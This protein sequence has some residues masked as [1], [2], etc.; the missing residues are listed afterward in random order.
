MWMI[1][2]VQIVSSQYIK[3]KLKTEFRE[4]PITIYFRIDL[5]KLRKFECTVFAEPLAT[6]S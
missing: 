3:L 1:T 4:I 2:L 5:Y 6:L